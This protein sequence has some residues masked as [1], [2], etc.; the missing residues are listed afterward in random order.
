[1]AT[2]EDLLHR[3]SALEEGKHR[4]SY[5]NGPSS[6]I[7]VVPDG[8]VKAWLQVLA[9]FF[10][11]FTTWALTD[12]FGAYQTFYENGDLFSA[13]SSSIAWI[14]STQAAILQTVGLISGT[15]YDRGYF[16]SLLYTA[17][18]VVILGQMMLSLSHTYYQVFL[19]QAVC[20]GLGAG[21]VAV[22]GITILSSYFDRRIEFAIGI[23]STGSG[24]GATIYPF[25]F[26]RIITRVGFAWCVRAIGLLMFIAMLVQV[27]VLRP[28]PRP[29]KLS[30]ANIIDWAAFREPAYVAFLLGVT[31]CTLSLNIPDYYIQ[32]YAIRNHI[33]GGDFGFYL[34]SILTTGSVCGQVSLSYLAEKIGPFNVLSC[35]I[36]ICGALCF[37]LINLQSM[38]GL[39]VVIT[40]YGFV[41]GAHMSLAPTCFVKLSPTKDVV[42]TRLGMGMAATVVGTLVGPPI[43]GAILDNVGFN[44]VWVYSGTVSIASGLIFMLSRGFHGGWRVWARV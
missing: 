9:A 15:L 16:R 22:P 20:M 6:E 13:S 17:S 19:A 25:M 11:Y 36:A 34:L 40:T 18:L 23:A 8:G 30:R 38:P 39:I 10:V 35:S 26:H 21:L 5:G 28:R 32:L 31:T 41:S 12:S 27:L 2:T 14:G 44:S 3:V 37:A 24:I 33:T 42:G 29:K 4:Q 7:Y 1:M 43:A